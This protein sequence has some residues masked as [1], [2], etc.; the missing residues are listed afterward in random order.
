MST[1]DT[2]RFLFVHNDWARRA[3]LDA[4]KEVDDVGLDRPF[5]L[6]PGSL[7]ATLHHLWRA[8]RVWLDRWRGRRS[9]IEQDRPGVAELA[10]RFDSTAAEREA[11]LEEVGTAGQ[12][13]PVDFEDSEGTAYRF[14]L[15]DLMMHVTNHGVH[16]RA[17]ALNMLRRLGA[18]VP[19]LDLLTMRLSD[20][21][22]PE[23]AYDPETLL[24]YDRYA[25][26]ARLR[27]IDHLGALRR[28]QF[29]RKAEMGPGSIRRT[30]LHVLD[31][32]RWWQDNWRGRPPEVYEPTD[33]SEDSTKI[34]A[35]LA[36]TAA[37]RRVQLAAMTAERL[38]ERVIARPSPDRELEFTLGDT[39]LQLSTHGAHH[40]AQL[41]NMLRREGVDPPVID[42]VAW[43]RAGSPN[44]V[45]GALERTG[46]PS[47]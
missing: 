45:A 15:G 47:G 42:V 29:D 40:R 8:E 5:E 14:P 31:A 23:V 37:S 43:L 12:S 17:Q 46:A 41:L 30:L 4:A 13:R 27:M 28:R 11:F 36:V 26:W 19:G 3:L 22:G 20:E 39:V 6:G 38:T 18:R 34:L 25:D 9:S 24:E 35:A 33:E 44:Y 1:V 32:E 16:H 7:R 2:L 21:P 10:D